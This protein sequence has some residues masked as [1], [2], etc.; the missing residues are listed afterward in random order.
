MSRP[1]SK[2][3]RARRGDAARAAGSVLRRQALASKLAPIGI[4]Y[5]HPAS[6]FGAPIKVVD[7]ATRALIDAWEARRS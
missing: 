7:A 6:Q 1:L 3:Q 5:A 2:A 4:T